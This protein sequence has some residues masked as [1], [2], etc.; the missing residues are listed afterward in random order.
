MAEE[1]QALE[2]KKSYLGVGLVPLPK[3]KRSI[4]NKWVY[5]VKRKADGSFFFLEV[6]TAC[7]KRLFSGVW[8]RLRLGW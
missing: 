7:S 2:R 3:G 4:G 8:L 5:K 1:L 6:Q